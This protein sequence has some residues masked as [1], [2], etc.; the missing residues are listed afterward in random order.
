MGVGTVR[1]AAVDLQILLFMA[2]V[3]RKAPYPL[4]LAWGGVGTGRGPCGG[5]EVARGAMVP[6]AHMCTNCTQVYRQLPLPVLFF[7]WACS[8][9]WLAD[10]PGS[11]VSSGLS[12]RSRPGGL[13]GGGGWCGEELVSCK[14]A[15]LES[16]CYR[17]DSQGSLR[18][19]WR[20]G[21]SCRR[22]I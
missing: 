2:C 19:P 16:R 6:Y 3:N 10:T 4:P 12:C 7:H 15:L 5:G 17:L 1:A 20:K 14:P 22:W 21:G 9:L 8:A 11:T 13:P 18:L